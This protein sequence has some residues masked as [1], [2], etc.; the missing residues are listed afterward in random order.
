M[1]VGR[2]RQVDVFTSAG[3][4]VASHQIDH[5]VNEIAF[6]DDGNVLGPIAVDA[7]F[8][9]EDER[10]NRRVRLRD[11]EVLWSSPM[12]APPSRPM[13]FFQPRTVAGGL[14]AAR[15]AVGMPRHSSRC[16][17]EGS[18]YCSSWLIGT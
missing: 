12:P 2:Y 9:A 1:A 6:G 15:V 13:S 10:Q 17:V 7:S 14:N 18:V 8:F 16:E 4:Q 5:P 11:D 3:E